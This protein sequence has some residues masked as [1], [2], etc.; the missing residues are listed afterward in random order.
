MI[1]HRELTDALYVCPS[2]DNHMNITP[3]D[4]FK[5]LYDHGAFEEIKTPE[6]LADPLKFK[7]QRRYS[8][9]MKEARKATGEREVMLV[10][11]GEI[12]GVTTICAGQNFNFMAGSMGMASATR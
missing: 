12:G 11:K 8:D 5:A 7:D 1:F 2:C 3:R 10:V 6:P 4:R 9:R